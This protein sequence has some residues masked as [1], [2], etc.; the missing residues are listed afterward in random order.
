MNT[1]KKFVFGIKAIGIK[2]VFETICASIYR[3]WIDFRYTI[4]LNVA[5]DRGIKPKDLVA[6]RFNTRGGTFNFASTTLNITFLTDDFVRVAWQPGQPPI[7]YALAPVNWKAVMIHSRAVDDGWLMISN[8]MQ[9][10]VHNDGSIDFRDADGALIRSHEPPGRVEDGW[11]NIAATHP[12]EHYYGLGEKAAP[13]NRRGLKFHL[14]NQDPGGSYAPGEDPLYMSIPV[15]LGI[16]KGGSYL[17]F[18]ENSFHGTVS[19]GEKEVVRFSGGMLRY[20]VATGRVDHLLK[21]YLNLTGLPPLPPK[22]ALGYHQSRWGYRS[23][24]E[25]R[26]VVKRFHDLDLPLSAIHLDIDYMD[27]YR[28]FTID[29]QRF[30]DM[31]ALSEDLRKDGVHLVAI[32]DP[33]VKIDPEYPVYQDGLE[34]DVFCKAPNGKPVKGRVWPG[35]CV[36][37][38]FLD[39]KGRNWWMHQYLDL[40]NDGIGG[41]WHDM[42]EPATFASWGIPSLPMMTQYSFEGRGGTHIEANNLYGLLMNQ[43]GHDALRRFRP[44]RRP[45]I[46]SRSGWAGIQRYAWNWTGDVESTWRGLRQTLTIMLGLGLSGVPFTGSD[47]GGFSGNPDAELF[48]RWFEMAAFTPF[49]RGHSSVSTKRREPWAFGEE[50]TAIVREILRLRYQLLPYIYTAAWQA[51]REGA[52]LMRPLFWREEGNPDLL[53]REDE[54][55]FGDWL[56]IA[57]V[58]DKGKQQREVLL[59]QGK[60][61]DFWRDR[62]YEGARTVT[63]PAPP[64]KIPVFVRQGAV[65]PFERENVLELQLYAPLDTGFKIAE[66]CLY[67]DAGDGY[68]EKRIDR[69]RVRKDGNTLSVDHQSEGGYRLPYSSIRVVLHGAAGISANV[70]EK[71]L[72]LDGN[73]FILEK[74]EP[75]ELSIEKE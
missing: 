26:D 52:P 14:R 62:V 22:W 46:L 13:L 29:K 7:P 20:Y 2:A 75:F 5:K 9:V 34:K 61:Y 72:A 15:F 58:L 6:P 41:F 67:S 39:D 17:I 68:G 25:V 56:L 19:F 12:D 36:F 48:V 11:E 27:G 31:W 69:F 28:V 3:D 8:A 23:D 66:S 63:V 38:D 71:Q 32:L 60:W 4:N 57:P 55:Y 47:I 33:G 44:N 30:P 43:A 18:F 35:W 54:F 16:H 24:A 1:I 49:F 53:D 37:P 64:G 65:I 42:N 10:L 21:C 50:A 40:L 73:A 74:L 70:R 51:S 59:P 45:W